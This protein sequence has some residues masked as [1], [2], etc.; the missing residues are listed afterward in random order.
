[1]EEGRKASRR[2]GKEGGREVGGEH[3]VR[4]GVM[5]VGREGWR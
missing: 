3:A 4:E 5:E 2:E 1:M